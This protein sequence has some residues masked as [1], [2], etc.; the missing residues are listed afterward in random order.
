MQHDLYCQERVQKSMRHGQG[1]T[2]YSSAPIFWAGMPK[3]QQNSSSLTSPSNS[4]SHGKGMGGNK[5]FCSVEQG[6]LVNT[7]AFH[8][9]TFGMYLMLVKLLRA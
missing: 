5:A 8:R 7:V 4:I 2:W 9:W 6:L 1:Y 3:T